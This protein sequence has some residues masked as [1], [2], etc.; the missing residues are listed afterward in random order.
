MRRLS[1][2]FVPIAYRP[3]N[4]ATPSPRWISTPRPAMLVEMV[5][6]PR[7]PARAIRPPHPRPPPAEGNTPPAPRHV[8][9]NGDRAALPG[10][11]HDQRLLLFIARVE[12]RVRDA[13][14]HAAQTLRLL[15]ARRPHQDGLAGGMHAPD[16]RGDGR[17][18]EI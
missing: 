17:F 11:S 15:D 10:A 16:L 3:P 7:C 2:R 18:L 13:G 14:Q 4:S 12:H 9:R 8:G 1:W 6:A 5:T